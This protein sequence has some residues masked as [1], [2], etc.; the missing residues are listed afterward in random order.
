[1]NCLFFC[2]YIMSRYL[3]LYCIIC[4]ISYVTLIKYQN[5]FG[6]FAGTFGGYYIDPKTWNCFNTCNSPQRSSFVVIFA[7]FCISFLFYVTVFIE[8]HWSVS[9]QF[10]YKYSWYYPKG[11]LAKNSFHSI[12]LSVGSYLS[13]SILRYF[14][15]DFKACSSISWEVFHLIL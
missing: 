14:E 7:H 1:M 4:V 6:N 11:Y 13:L 15:A 3:Y 9:H 8:N 10:Y 2:I 5:L 12:S